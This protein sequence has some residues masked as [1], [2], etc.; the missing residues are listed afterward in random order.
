M[1]S[2]GIWVQKYGSP[3]TLS[4][5]RDK[6]SGGDL[7]PVFKSIKEIYHLF[8]KQDINSCELYPQQFISM[9]D[10]ACKKCFQVKLLRLNIRTLPF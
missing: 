3:L 4:T 10:C 1:T 5:A 6:R 8:R 7:V 9:C 2:A